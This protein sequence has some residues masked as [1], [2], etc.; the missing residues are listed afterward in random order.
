LLLHAN[1]GVDKSKQKLQVLLG[2]EIQILN[3]FQFTS[4]NNTN[5]KGPV[6][7]LVRAVHS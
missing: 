5:L 6:A 3:L 4:K 2:R 1:S 7:Q